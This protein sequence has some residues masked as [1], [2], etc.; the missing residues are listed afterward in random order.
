MQFRRKNIRLPAQNYRGRGWFFITLCCDARQ[1]VFADGQKARWLINCLRREAKASRFGV[2]AFC[3]MPDHVHI[4]VE[5]QE[6]ASDSPRIRQGFEAE[7]KLSLP[8]RVPRTVVAKEIL[9]SHSSAVRCARHGCVVHLDE[10]RAEGNLRPT[11]GVSLLRFVHCAV[12]KGQATRRVLDSTLEKERR[13]RLKAAATST[14]WHSFAS[15]RS[16]VF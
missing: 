6:S 9:R 8:K 1:Q 5:G 2:H 11:E 14:V 3:V 4:L 16:R 12:G 15:A 13:A 10:F 7:D